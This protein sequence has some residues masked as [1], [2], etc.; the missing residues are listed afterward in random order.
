MKSR[1]LTPGLFLLL[2]FLGSC[3]DSTSAPVPSRIVV[4]PGS[5][6]MDAVG[7]T[8][9]YSATVEDKK[10][11]PITGSAV[12]WTTT[13]GTVASVSGSGL[14]TGLKRGTTAIR[15][16]AEGLTGSA[17]L[18]VSPIPTAVV[19]NA[20]DGQTGA[21]SQ[22]LPEN[23]EVEVLDSQGNPIQG[24]SVSFIATVGGGAVSPSMATTDAQGRATAAWTLGC[25]NDDPQR[26]VAST[27][28]I[29]VEFTASANLSLPAICQE[30]IPDGRVTFSYSVQLEVVG[31]DQ[32]TMAW[33]VESG[34]L[35]SGVDLSASGVLAGTP[36]APGTFT[37]RAKAQDGMGNSAARDFG[38]RICEAPLALAPGESLTVEPSGSSACGFFLPSGASGNRYRV[39]VLWSTSNEGDTLNLPMVTVSVSKHQAGAMG[40]APESFGVQRFAFPQEEG[41]WLEGLPGHLREAME[42]DAAT[43]AFHHRLRAEELQMI[44]EMGPGARL[45][46][47]AGSPMRAV[48]LQSAAPDK[49]TLF[50]NPDSKCEPITAKV[51]ALKVAENDHAVFYQD[52]AQAQIDSLK[53]TTALAEMLLNY[54]EDYGKTVIDEY[55][56]GVSDIDED[57]RI[58]VFATPV[59]DDGVAAYVWSGD[60][61]ETSSCGNSNERELVRFNAG[62]I[63]G[64]L[65]GNFQALATL[66]HEAKHVSSLYK[67]ISRYYASGGVDGGYQPG[68]IE[69]GTAEI[70]GEM[71]SRL[72]WEAA[73]GPA[74]GS[75]IRR[76]DKVITEESYGVLLRWVRTI[77]YLYSQ[78]NGVVGTPVGASSGHSVYGSGWHFHRWLGDSYGN[79]ASAR[80]ADGPFFVA[81]NDSL[82]VSG[83]QGIRDLTGKSWPQLL[84]EYATALMLIGTGAP[85]PEWAITSYDFPDVTSGLLQAPHQPPGYYPWP[86]NVSGDNTTQTFSS[87]VSMGTVGPSGIR[88]YDLTSD[89]TGAGIS[90]K[91]ETTRDPVRIVVVRLQ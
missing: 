85:Q 43:E 24:A 58:T 7:L 79:A 87:F 57:G 8:Q 60:F 3:G 14:A 53:V 16:T 46:P 84:D 68:W 48:G 54:Y 1:L 78:P 6:T 15:A 69:E 51:T 33:T 37:F 11:K 80:L 66:V 38:L 41:D 25:S 86:V 19:K 39:G 27:S 5:V 63:R 81:L 29:S 72:A 82:A 40:V 62:V 50:A 36:T 55:F 26:V 12:S 75:M 34:T 44:R 22:P 77:N 23:L 28:G 89:G 74:V 90:V 67:S 76:S 71:S 20:G 91:V 2:P 47:D 70:A 9:Q 21:L 88:V 18:T 83:A 42:I 13:D 65:D 45:L 56:D 49:L 31:G 10:G 59:V 17:T 61:F 52:S 35:P 30:S 64:M 32:P 73:G 4:T